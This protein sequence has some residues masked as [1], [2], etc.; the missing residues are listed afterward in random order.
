MPNVRVDAYHTYSIYQG[1]TYLG[2]I[3]DVQ[4]EFEM[5]QKKD[6]LAAETSVTVGINVDV[7]TLIVEP[8]QDEAGN[9]IL[10]ENNDPIYEERKVDVVGN[11]N[12]EAL[13]QENNT[14]IITEHRST[15]VSL[16]G[17]P[18]FSNVKVFEGWI[19]SWTADLNNNTVTF[20]AVSKGIDVADYALTGGDTVLNSQSDDAY[21][22][23]SDF[24]M[25]YGAWVFQQI[26]P[27]SP[28]TLNKMK[29]KM[30]NTGSKTQNVTFTIY[31]GDCTNNYV[32]YP[33]GSIP[34]IVLSG[35]EVL[36]DNAV[37]TATAT[38]NVPTGVSSATEYTVTFPD[39]VTLTSG[40]T[41]Y[42]YIHPTFVTTNDN[43][44]WTMYGT[45]SAA[46]APFDDLFYCYGNPPST[47]NATN[48]SMVV[49]YMDLVSSTGATTVTY[50][51][52]DPTATMLTSAMDNYISQGGATLYAPSTIE[53]SGVTA[54]YT[55]NT[56]TMYDVIKKTVALAGEGWYYYIHP[57][58]LYLHVHQT[59]LTADHT[60]YKGRHISNL[61]IGGTVESVVNQV[62]FSGGDTGGGENLFLSFSNTTSKSEQRG[63]QRLKMLTD[64]RVTSSTTAG[65]FANNEMDSHAGV[66]YTSSITIEAHKYSDFTLISIGETVKIGGYGNFLDNVLLQ[67]VGITR[68][69]NDVVL[70][71]GILEKRQSDQIVEAQNRLDELSTIANPTAPS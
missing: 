29:F 38:V 53:T 30:A 39:S 43:D 20:S 6:S 54:S 10:D 5:S 9:N 61:Q 15:D 70:D 34:D 14:I 58:T 52:L 50:S 25:T 57:S 32:Y 71:L 49:L 40:N 45:T 67:I 65:L 3:H 36:C 26:T 22:L 11:A 1:S 63:R 47:V 44:G 55:F 2:Q 7:A 62:Y 24:A 16:L 33:H 27:A 13:I 41:Y 68:H 56:A 18:V 12:P 48:G 64:N 17:I 51:S 37:D 69:A 4:S 31:D 59:S 35:S 60:F 66:E 21:S 19:E 8:L 23:T 28:I 42:V 46:S